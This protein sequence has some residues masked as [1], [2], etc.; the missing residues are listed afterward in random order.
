MSFKYLKTFEQWIM[1]NESKLHQQDVFLFL[2]RFQP[3]HIGHL[4]SMQDL[5]KYF[6]CPGVIALVYTDKKKEK[7]PFSKDLLEKEFDLI[8]KNEKSLVKDFI[9]INKGYIPDI[10]KEFQKKDFNIIGAGCGEDRITSYQLQVKSMLLPTSE[11][12]VIPDFELKLTNRYGSATDVRNAIKEGD[13]Q[14]FKKLM[15]KY[16]NHLYNEFKQQIN[17]Q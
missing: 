7:S 2:G 15:P 11:V 13:Q 1:Y 6:N 17:I 8:L 5:S 16:L 12:H 9:I 10:I 14:V 3:F 4:K